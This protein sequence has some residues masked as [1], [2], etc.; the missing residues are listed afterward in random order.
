MKKIMLFLTLALAT[1]LLAV[2][3]NYGSVDVK[4][5]AE[6]VAPTNLMFRIRP[7]NNGNNI[8]DRFSFDFK[9]I[10]KGGS[11]TLVG[12][13][14]LTILDAQFNQVKFHSV[15]TVTMVETGVENI[16]LGNNVSNTDKNTNAKIDYDLISLIPSTNL[17]AYIG[18]LSVTVDAKGPNVVAGTLLDSK[19]SIKATIKNQDTAGVI[20]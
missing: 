6:V 9:D 18:E 15:P 10:V 20:N 17:D 4:V 8:R 13:Y 11:Q 1:Q 16:D 12:Q 2:E 14:D 19:Y 3:K 7:L 5:I